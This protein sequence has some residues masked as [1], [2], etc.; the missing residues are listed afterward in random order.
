MTTCYWL[1][2]NLWLTQSYTV[3]ALVQVLFVG[4]LLLVRLVVPCGFAC[5]RSLGC[6]RGGCFCRR[7]GCLCRVLEYCRIGYWRIFPF[8]FHSCHVIASSIKYFPLALLFYQKLLL[9]TQSNLL[10]LSQHCPIYFFLEDK[11]QR[12]QEV[13]KPAF[14]AKL[15]HLQDLVGV[16]HR[17][18]DCHLFQT[19]LAAH[20][21]SYK[22]ITSI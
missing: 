16:H 19:T 8:M 7:S 14:D 4:G 1:F 15:S 22:K 2:L 10:S 9:I 12:V 6:A 21:I 13:I 17:K 11:R 3:R 18:S 20:C 5:G